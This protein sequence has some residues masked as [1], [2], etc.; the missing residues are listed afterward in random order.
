MM[1][2]ALPSGP[3]ARDRGTGG[4]DAGGFGRR[5][6]RFQDGGHGS[7][8]T[9]SGPIV[10]DQNRLPSSPPFVAFIGNLPFDISDT[11]IRTFMSMNV[12]I[13]AKS[14]VS[15]SLP[16]DAERR[17]RGFGYVEFSSVEELTRALLASNQ[18]QIRQRV[19]RLDVSDSKGNAGSG[20]E[21]RPSDNAGNWRDG[22]S[23]MAGSIFGS[24]TRKAP[25][26]PDFAAQSSEPRNWRDAPRE[27]VPAPAFKRPEASL[28]GGAP[29]PPRAFAAAEEEPVRNWRDAAHPTE[30]KPHAPASAGAH[31]QHAP[32]PS[33]KTVGFGGGH[34]E[35]AAAAGSWRRD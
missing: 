4:A 21:P 7:M 5:P 33:K 6:G 8:G 29:R 30:P 17:S 32:R 13:P 3:S 26:G 18:H 27:F 35:Q 19:I 12:S 1:D 15:I 24:S 28:A 10:L 23:P 20:R 9:G 34:A 2:N 22:A 16:V 25:A 11:D 14:I 31:D